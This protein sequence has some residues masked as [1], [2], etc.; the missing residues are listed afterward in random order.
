MQSHRIQASEC[1]ILF[2]FTFG[3]YADAAN[4]LCENTKNA[5]RYVKQNRSIEVRHFLDSLLLDDLQTTIIVCFARLTP[6][7]E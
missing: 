7:R 4:F 1:S 2:L 5:S 3:F 6:I